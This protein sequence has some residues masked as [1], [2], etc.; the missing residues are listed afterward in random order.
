M[1]ELSRER[2]EQIAE[3]GF[4]GMCESKVLGQMSLQSLTRAELLRDILNTDDARYFLG[5][6]IV[7]KIKANLEGE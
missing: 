4:I 7:D 1:P 2:L 5:D 3:D 6:E